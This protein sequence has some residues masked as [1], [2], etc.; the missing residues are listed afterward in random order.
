MYS[1]QTKKLKENFGGKQLIFN[2]EAEPSPLV[3]LNGEASYSPQK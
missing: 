3:K 2:I 1:K